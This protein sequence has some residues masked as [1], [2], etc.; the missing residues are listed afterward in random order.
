MDRIRELK[1]KIKKNQEIELDKLRKI[2]ENED[3]HEIDNY[4]EVYIEDEMLIIEYKPIDLVYFKN[5]NVIIENV[6]EG[7]I[8]K[9][10]PLSEC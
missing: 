9:E 2:I 6:Y 7:R 5:N 8:P 10:M 4:I 1:E 3:Y